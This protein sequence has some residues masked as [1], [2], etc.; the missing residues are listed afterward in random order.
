MNFASHRFYFV[1]TVT[2]T[3]FLKWSHLSHAS[4]QLWPGDSPL[5]EIVE[6][7]CMHG[8]CGPTVNQLRIRL[9]FNNTGTMLI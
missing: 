7:A 6:M 1:S 2:R 4:Q 3:I 9:N 8:A 5:V